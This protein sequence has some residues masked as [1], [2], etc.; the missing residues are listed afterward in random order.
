MDTK[1]NFAWVDWIIAEREKNG[2]TQARLAK[3]AGLS[4]TA[5]SDYEKR[6]RSNPDEKS[7]SSI[8]VAF[9]YPPEHL[10]RIAN[11]LPPRPELD[12]VMGS[13]E[14][15]F[16]TYKHPETREQ[17]LSYLRFLMVEERKKESNA[18]PSIPPALSK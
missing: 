3:K 5:I 17:A 12:D 6:K 2:W 14:H 1:D 15:I 18:K 7:L 11:I 16:R 8:A 9:G 10:L 4:R 13:V